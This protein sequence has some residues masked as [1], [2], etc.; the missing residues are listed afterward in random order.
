[1][2]TAFTREQAEEICEDFEDLVDTDITIHSEEDAMECIID[3]VVMVPHDKALQQQ[4]L[5]IYSA[6]KNLMEAQSLYSGDEYDVLILA[7]NAND[8]DEVV[9]LPI[10]EYIEENGVGY[11]F[12][13]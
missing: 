10:R 7:C 11:N 2:S 8:E 4:F 1:M 3:H 12:P 6:G 9:I 13:E 5:Q